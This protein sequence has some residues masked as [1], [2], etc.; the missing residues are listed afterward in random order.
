MSLFSG[1]RL[2]PAVYLMIGATA[3]SAGPWFNVLDYGA[4]N[5]GSAS[6]TEA[7]RSAVQAAKAA[8]GGT[9]YIPA[10]KYVSGPIELVS[11]L[12]LHI[13]AG[14]T[15]QFPATRLPFTRGRWQ[16]VECILP[17]PLVGGRGLENVTITGRG[18]LTTSQPEWI[19]VMRRPS[20]GPAWL[21]LLKLLELKKPVPEEEYQKAALEHLPMFV[22][23]MDSHNILIEGIRIVG[24]AMWPIQILYS[25]KAVIRGVMV[26]T[27][28]GASTGGI[29]IDSSRN[30]RI[31]DCYIDTG[32]DGIVLKSGKDADGLRVNRP[33]ENVTITNCTVYRAHGAVVVGSETSGG[34]RNVVASN[35]ICQ[36]TQM[37]VRMKSRRGRGGVVEDLRFDNWTMEDVGQ[38]INMTTYYNMGPENVSTPP[39]EP[40]SERTPVFRNIAISNMTINRARV[41]INL[42][43]LPE[44][45]I[46]GV[47]ISDVIVSG[48]G[49]MKAR[50]TMAL[51]LH[52]VQVNADSGPAFLVRDSGELELDT[53]STRKPLADAPVIRLDRC[54][55]AIVRTS[56]ALRGTGTFVSVAPGELRSVVLEG[57]TLGGARKAIEEA[58]PK[59]SWGTS[60]PPTER[61][62]P[63]RA[64][65]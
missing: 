53:V 9:V 59:E 55:G 51:E 38:G 21:G 43:G 11:N 1:S 5:D 54:P 36:G 34:V 45:P 30:V 64:N 40:V 62:S 50:H 35:I 6:A 16:G 23:L 63:R 37:G 26:E 33:T 19:K 18:M 15:L 48:R 8:G 29:Y 46:T 31:S 2:L 24:S 57:N 3:W 52:N 20:S 28:P 12:V 22:S 13:E 58:P 25:D 56:K 42:E 27:Y 41:A 39:E 44:M 61:E 32:D 10:G 7:I 17:V 4:R 47:R 60:E 49:G 14:A 65:R